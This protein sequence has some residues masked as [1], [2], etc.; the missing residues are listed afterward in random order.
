[1]PFDALILSRPLFGVPIALQIL[2]ASFAIGL[3]SYLV[4]LEGLW[5]STGTLAFRN[6][7]GVW[8]RAFLLVLA[9][10]AFAILVTALEGMLG[11]A[12]R[13]VAREFPYRPAELA[14]SA[15]LAT[16]LV[17]GAVASFRLLRDVHDVESSLALRMAIGMFVICAP[18]ELAVSDGVSPRPKAILALASAVALLGLW[19]ALLCWRAA[20]ERSKPFLAAC[21]AMGPVGVVAPMGEWLGADGDLSL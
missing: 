6:L 5:L 11:P 12:W 21:L 18:L 13:A 14:L 17:V 15:Y 4:V 19:G 9:A 10:T 20:P 2:L 3:A 7:R 16:A 8:M 1:M